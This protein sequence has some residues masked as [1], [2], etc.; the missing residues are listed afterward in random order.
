MA[1]AAA[2]AATAIAVVMATVA[3]L[4]TAGA[5][6]ADTV[7]GTA[8]DTVERPLEVATVAVAAADI[9]AAVEVDSTVVE[10]AVDSMA[11][12]AVMVAADTGNGRLSTNKE[13]LRANWSAAVLL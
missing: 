5:M 1:I 12:A 9:T 8:V 11:A 2:G 6:V 4:D 3:V 10:A 13:R 7:V